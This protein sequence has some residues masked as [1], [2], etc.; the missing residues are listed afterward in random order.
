[1]F[2][3]KGKISYVNKAFAHVAGFEQSQMIADSIKLSFKFKDLEKLRTDKM[4]L[5]RALSNLVTNAIQ[6][7]PMGGQLQLSGHPQEGKVI[8]CVSDTGVGIPDEFK[9]KLFTPMMTTNQ[10]VKASDYQYPSDS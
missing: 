4:L 2:D 7:M 1:M 10:R 5:Q 9:P 6:A 3:K 8:I